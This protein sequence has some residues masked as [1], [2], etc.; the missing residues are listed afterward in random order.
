MI[1]S[2]IISQKLCQLLQKAFLKEKMKKTNSE[3]NILESLNN[4]RCDD[5]IHLNF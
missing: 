5:E 2:P 3:N 1:I 4:Y